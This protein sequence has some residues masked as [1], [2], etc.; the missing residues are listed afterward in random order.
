MAL[1]DE[2]TRGL[3]PLRVAHHGD[4]SIRVG[5]GRRPARVVDHVQDASL[6]VR[7][8]Q[9]DRKQIVETP[10]REGSGNLEGVCGIDVHALVEEAVAAHAVSAE[11]GHRVGHLEGGLAVRTPGASIHAAWL[12]TSYGIS[13]WKKISVPLLPFQITSYF[14]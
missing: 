6:P 13:F 4:R 7:W 10:R 2:V 11:A 9:E 12:G 3:N 14:W 1:Y 8:I 5:D